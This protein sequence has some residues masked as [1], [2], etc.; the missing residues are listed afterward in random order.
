MPLSIQTWDEFE[1]WET[2]TIEE[3]QDLSWISNY[4]WK[5]E[6]ISCVLVPRNKQWF[7]S[8][9][10]QLIAIWDTILEERRTGYEHRAPQKRAVKPIQE[11]I[12]DLQINECLIVI[13]KI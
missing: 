4:Y 6:I 2:K 13:K 1:V 5:L 3:N 7:E 8:N 9:V 12:S 11:S 10:H